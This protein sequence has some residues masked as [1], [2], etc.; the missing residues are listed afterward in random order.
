[1]KLVEK[2]KAF[3]AKISEYITAGK[4]IQK[5]ISEALNGKEEEPEVDEDEDEEEEEEEAPKR[6]AKKK[7]V[8]KKK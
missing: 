3:I 7:K 6:S 1:M 5:K 8:N 4:D 2:I